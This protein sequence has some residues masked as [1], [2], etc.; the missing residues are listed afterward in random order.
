M[1]GSGMSSV[2]TV[3][4]SGSDRG[5]SENGRKSCVVSVKRHYRHPDGIIQHYTITVA[6]CVLVYVCSRLSFLPIVVVSIV[7]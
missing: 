4:L 6:Q 1:L 3:L 7:Y 5:F 2:L